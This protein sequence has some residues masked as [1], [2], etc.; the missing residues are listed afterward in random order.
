MPNTIKKVGKLS[1]KELPDTYEALCRLYLPRPIHS[2]VVCAEALSYIE[3]LSGYDLNRDQEDYLEALSTF[4]HEYEQRLI[5]ESR[6]IEPLEILKHLLEENGLAAK[7]LA[8]ILG[9]DN[10]L[11][12]RI[13]KGSR[14]ITPEHAKRLGDR[15]KVRPGLFLGLN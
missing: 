5:G 15:F 4:V 7:D 6:D 3:A 12:S 10:S 14:K 8:Q 2:K 9:V 11:A 13:L 1:F